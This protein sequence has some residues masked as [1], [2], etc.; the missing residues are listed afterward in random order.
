V[1][2]L[3]MVSAPPAVYRSLLTAPRLV[4]WKLR[5]WLGVMGRRR[6][7]SWV[8]TARNADRP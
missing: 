7:V 1:S 8:R 4:V 6:D 2:G 5:L 3:R